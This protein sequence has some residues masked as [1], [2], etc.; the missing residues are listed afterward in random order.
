M[1]P[2]LNHTFTAVREASRYALKA[3]DRLDSVRI[4][5]KSKYE[6]VSEVDINVQ[7]IICDALLDHMPDLKIISEEK[8]QT[9]FFNEDYEWALILDP[10]DGTHNYIHHIPFCCISLA[11]VKKNKHTQKDEI[12]LA[13]VYDFIHDELFHAE[14]GRGAY[15]NNH[16]IRVSQK[17]ELAHTITDTCSH[18]SYLSPPLKK[19]NA[20]TR[21]YGSH[22]LSLAHCAAGRIDATVYKTAKIWDFAAGLLLIQE[23]GGHSINLAGD[24]FH[25]LDQPPLIAASPIIAGKISQLIRSV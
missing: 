3:Q 4:E 6:F 10:I 12:E 18:F 19:K 2:L 5:L 11:F 22:A 7:N 9:F 17:R 24:P 23:A 8:E 21:K 13:L 15:C 25:F 16:R 20:Y 14:R 1:H